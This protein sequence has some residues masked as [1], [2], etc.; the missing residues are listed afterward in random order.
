VQRVLYNQLHWTGLGKTAR[1]GPKTFISIW[2]TIEPMKENIRVCEEYG[3]YEYNLRNY[4]KNMETWIKVEN[5]K[6]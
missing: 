3:S 2:K 6:K 1:S 4:R 5:G